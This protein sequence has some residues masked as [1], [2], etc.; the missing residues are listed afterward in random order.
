MI[1]RS[2]KDGGWQYFKQ[3]LGFSYQNFA[4]QPIHFHCASVGELLT[5]KPLILRISAE[6]PNK[7]IVIT[8]NTPT[9][10]SLAN[11]LGHNAISHHY[12]PIDL[13]FSVNRFLNK[14]KPSCSLILETE[15]WPTYYAHAAQQHIPIA[16]INARLTSKTTDSNSFLKNEFSHA[17][18]KVDLLL[19]R[20]EDDCQRYNSLCP[21]LR[22][23]HV[24][25]N[26]KYAVTN[27]TSKQLACTT[28]KRP[29]FLA[30][31]T[32]D[33]EELQLIEHI[34]LLKRKNYLLILAPRYPD[35]CKQISQQLK[36][37]GL[38]VSVR[39]DH[40]EI[41][42]TTDVYLADTLGE[43]NMFYNE[44]ALVFVGGSLIPRG[45]HNILE[46]AS[47]G[48]CIIVGP[49]TNNFAL[50]T[51]ELLQADA[52][53]QVDSN[54]QLGLTLI[55]FLKDDTLR[56]QYG[57]NAMQFM[58]SRSGILDAYIKHLHLLIES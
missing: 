41:S 10:A 49:Y 24:L 55:K 15:I 11:K 7:Q 18:N 21:N 52:L 6:Y 13:A 26:L 42:N 33:D 17:L 46:P 27:T 23:A 31:S 45:G 29:F 8:T 47:F 34:E 38:Q 43:L 44:S 5:A 35:R 16:I 36:S 30:A 20:S 51:K 57:K 32:H 22:S 12:F 37:M 39:S 19:A 50:E 54:H 48:K 40:E 53:L 4:S 1:Y 2:F 56:E 9:A 14:V 58:N 25:G 28:I 3:R